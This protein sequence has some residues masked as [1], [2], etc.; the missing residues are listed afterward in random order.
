MDNGILERTAAVNEGVLSSECTTGLVG[1]ASSGSLGDVV[2]DD[3]FGVAIRRSWKR[4]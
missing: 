1:E 3:T 4:E 2:A